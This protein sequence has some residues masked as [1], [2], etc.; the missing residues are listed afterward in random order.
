MLAG[1][2]VEYYTQLERGNAR[3][4]S[5]DVLAGIADALQLDD[6]ER[7]HLMDIV[8]A[9]QTATRPTRRRGT[10]RVRPGVQGVL[11]AI[12]GAARVRP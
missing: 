7:D 11:D 12:T 4:A 9:A 5:D 3:G 1:I 2:S 8:R 6:D 10:D